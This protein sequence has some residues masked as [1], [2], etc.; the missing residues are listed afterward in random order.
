MV[1]SK[2][3]GGMSV[4][5]GGGVGLLEVMRMCEAAAA[6]LRNQHME[7]EIQRRLSAIT[8]EQEDR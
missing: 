3:D 8:Q 4:N 1:L 5:V 6:H 2:D 7:A